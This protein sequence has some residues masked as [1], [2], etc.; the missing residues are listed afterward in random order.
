MIKYFTNRLA[1]IIFTVISSFA[2]T[3]SAETFRVMLHTGSFPPYFFK[4]GDSRTGT[5]RDIFTAITQETGDSVEYI[6]VPF[7][8]AL[9][10]FETGKIDI[11][12]MTNPI[13]RQSSSVMGNYSI[14]FSVSE[15]IILFRQDKYIAVHSPEDFLGKTVGVING[16]YYP[17]YEPYFADGRIKPN[18]FNSEKKLIQLLLAGRLDQAFINKDFALYQI[19][20]QHLT[21]QLVIGESNSVVDQMIRFH[22]TKKSAL[23]R[24]NKAIKKLIKD[25]SIEHIYE[26]YR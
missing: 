1:A 7:K 21:E 19:K 12:P 23:P 25:G 11:E 22:P 2:H 4:E 6:R 10:Q 20:K 16:Y 24:F 13:W 17:A 26:R 9:R 18:R 15:E 14:P 8:R 5:I 3:G